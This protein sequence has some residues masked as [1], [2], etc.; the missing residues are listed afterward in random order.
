MMPHSDNDQYIS[1]RRNPC[2]NTHL[3]QDAGQGI[4]GG[5]G[6]EIADSPHFCVIEAAKNV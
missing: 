1:H 2:L 6:K 4:L 3:F 5:H